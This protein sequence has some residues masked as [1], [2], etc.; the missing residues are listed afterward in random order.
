MTNG[1]TGLGIVKQK[2]DD[3]DDDDNDSWL[4]SG[5]VVGCLHAPEKGARWRGVYVC[6]CA[7]VCGWVAGLATGSLFRGSD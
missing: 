1:G 3:D 2:G 7:C 6:M 4:L 5:W